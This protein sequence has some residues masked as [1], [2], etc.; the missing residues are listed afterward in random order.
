MA[1]ERFN[2]RVVERIYNVH[3]NDDITAL[4]TSPRPPLWSTGQSSSLQTERPRVRF[5]AIPDSLRSSG[6]G[7]GCT[8]P[9][10]YN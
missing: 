8:Q 7:T 1:G 4:C 2:T 3:K 10:E 6:Y 5:P 9:R